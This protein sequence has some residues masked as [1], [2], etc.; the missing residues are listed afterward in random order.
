MENKQTACPDPGCI[1]GLPSDDPEAHG[2]DMHGD[3]WWCPLHSY[4]E[5]RRLTKYA[6]EIDWYDGSIRLR[7]LAV[8]ECDADRDRVRAAARRQGV[9]YKDPEVQRQLQRIDERADRARDELV[10]LR[11][12]RDEA[13]ARHELENENRSNPEQIYGI[14]D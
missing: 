14:S 10:T 3:L 4:G 5:W 2:W 13:V 1:Y 9:Y 12:N 6:E 7:E 8:A 11:R